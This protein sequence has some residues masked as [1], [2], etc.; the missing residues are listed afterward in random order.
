VEEIAVVAGGATAIEVR[1]ALASTPGG[2]RRV[3]YFRA[4]QPFSAVG[5]MAAVR[6][7]VGANP[8]VLM[9]GDSL[10]PSSL[11]SLLKRFSDQQPD[12]LLA[13]AGV[14]APQT[15]TVVEVV[16]GRP[17][18][19]VDRPLTAGSTL[20]LA[21][22]Q[23]FSPSVFDAVRAT[24]PSWRGVPELADAITLMIE[25]GAVVEVERT[26]DWWGY[27]PET[28]R[29]LKANRMVLSRLAAE[30]DPSGLSADVQLQGVVK[31]DGTASLESTV[32]RGPVVIGAGARVVDS[33][34]GPYSSIGSGVTIEGAEVEHSIILPGASIRHVGRR[35]EASLVG[36]NAQVFRDFSLPKALR[37]TV[38][39]SAA[40][41]LA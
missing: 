7:F 24:A 29:I 31:I 35:L 40:I 37:I 19:L 10:F 38:G 5:A 6:D 3:T 23:V 18:G 15:Q 21:G 16:D 4:D 2:A 17:V 39:D 1:D 36:R 13:V 26:D 27:S 28:D 41:A 11:P 33:Y 12:A 34:I 30:P 22:A 9:R 20:A 32:I 25:A 8:F 14:T